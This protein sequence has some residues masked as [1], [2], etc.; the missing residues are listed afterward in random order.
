MFRSFGFFSPV[1][2]LAAVIAA[3]ATFLVVCVPMS[4]LWFG[5]VAG[6]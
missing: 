2:A 5:G 1:G 4:T 6:G 3:A